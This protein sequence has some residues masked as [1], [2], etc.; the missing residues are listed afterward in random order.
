MNKTIVECIFVVLVFSVHIFLCFFNLLWTSVWKYIIFVIISSCFLQIF[1]DGGLS[2][3]HFHFI[4][5]LFK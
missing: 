2:F 3:A 4:L 1:E 5:F